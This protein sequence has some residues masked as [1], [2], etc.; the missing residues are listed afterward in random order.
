MKKVIHISLLTLT[1]TFIGTINAKRIQRK[2]I[3]VTKNEKQMLID[4]KALKTA[5]S[6]EEQVAAAQKLATDLQKDP[7]ALLELEEKKIK[8]EIK[9]KEQE[10]K[11]LEDDDL[12]EQVIFEKEELE[13]QLKT[14]QNKLMLYRSVRP[15]EVS[16]LKDWALYTLIGTVGLAIADQLITGGA[17][18]TALMTGTSTV[19]GKVSSA[20]SAAWGYIPST[21]DI[22]EKTK[23][24]FGYGASAATLGL[25]LLNMKD[26]AKRLSAELSDEESK[27]NPDLQKIDLLQ[28]QLAEQNKRI[29]ELETKI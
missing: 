14:V 21:A 27:P 28:K 22:W 7:Y 11:E 26:L 13:Q 29:A 9:E 5:S 25:T 17:G 8:E 4:T 3:P 10:I 1:L 12:I 16:R 20:A 2:T 18:R 24:A 19:A 23:S 15:K 6:P